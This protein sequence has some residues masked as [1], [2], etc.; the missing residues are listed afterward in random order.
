VTDVVGEEEPAAQLRRSKATVPRM[1]TK[2]LDM[3]FQELGLTV[4]LNAVILSQTPV[5]APSSV[6]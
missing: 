4:P 3:Y 1:L 2:R 5:A 6:I